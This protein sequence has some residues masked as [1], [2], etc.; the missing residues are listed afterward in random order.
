M[1]TISCFFDMKKF[2]QCNFLLVLVSLVISWFITPIFFCFLQL[3][4][5]YLFQN[6]YIILKDSDIEQ[7]QEDDITS[8]STVLSVSRDTACILLRHFNW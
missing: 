7:R 6:N 2:K 3:N 1:S 5:C 4:V 8:V